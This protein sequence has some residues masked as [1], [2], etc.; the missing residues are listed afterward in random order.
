MYALA[1]FAY[2]AAIVSF[3]VIF[4]TESHKSTIDTVIVATDNTGQNG[5][6]CQMISKVTATYEVAASDTQEP[7][8]AYQLVN[9]IESKAQYEADYAIADPCAQPMQYFPGTSKPLF[10]GQAVHYGAS[11]MYGSDL[12]YIFTEEDTQQGIML[13]NYTA[14]KFGGSAPNL[15]M[16]THSI[17]VDVDGSPIVLS[18]TG[19]N[20]Y[21]VFRIYTHLKDSSELY[22]IALEYPP[23]I[24]NDNLYNIY[25]A[26]H[27]TFTALDVY[28]D[29][30]D[31]SASN[32][33]LFTTRD[34]EYITYAAVYNSGSSVK[35]YY[36]NNTD[37]ANVWEGG[38]F[39]GL[40]HVSGCV[41]V[42]VDA[43]DNAYYI[44][45]QGGE[46]CSSLLSL[47]LHKS[48]L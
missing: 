28:S 39:R 18:G 29:N 32:T 47:H 6:T 14:G 5:Y 8:Q 26:E 23:I 40:M 4:V 35:V 3:S 41:G 25:L 27:D 20:T 19:S 15:T 12:A 48:F 45:F 7:V 1:G 17:A 30:S 22:S 10:Q 9:L 21:G 43:Q 11:V 24:L 44:L 37:G 42:A 33:T 2:I 31:G 38:V 13:M 34:G 46:I 16:L 36:V